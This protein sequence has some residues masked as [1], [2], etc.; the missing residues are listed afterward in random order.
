MPSWNAYGVERRT[1]SPRFGVPSSPVSP[2]RSS[3]CARCDVGTCV[4]ELGRVLLRATEGVLLVLEREAV[5]V[6]E[7]VH[8]ALRDA[9]RAAR[10]LLAVGHD[11]RSCWSSGSGL[12]VPSMKP[13]RSRL[14]R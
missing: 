7:V 13:V 12:P 4:G 10:A 6:V 3:T 1:I 2:S 8:P 11:A 9:E 5:E 14:L